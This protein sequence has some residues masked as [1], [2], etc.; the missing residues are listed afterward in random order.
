MVGRFVGTFLM[1]FFKASN[2]LAIYAIVSM[3]LCLVAITASGMLAVYTIIGI[4]FFMSIMFPTIFSLG[5]KE[6]GSDTKFGSSLI[7]M[8]IVG[9]AI[10]PPIMGYIADKSSIQVGYVVP[11]IC[12]AVVFMFG[13]RGHRIIRKTLN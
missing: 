9:G 3:A 1:K 2:L 5:I 8:S 7:I 11:F 12:F 13:L 4:A 10:L 6:L